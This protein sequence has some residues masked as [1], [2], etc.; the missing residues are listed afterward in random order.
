[1][2][3]IQNKGDQD[4]QDRWGDNIV[5]LQTENEVLV[6]DYLRNEFYK[7]MYKGL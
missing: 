2:E 4:L 1:M 5:G 6:M 3:K 7:M